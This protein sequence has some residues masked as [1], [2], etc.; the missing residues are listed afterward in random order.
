[1][2]YQDHDS[3]FMTQVNNSIGILLILPNISVVL[4]INKPEEKKDFKKRHYPYA[5]SSYYIS[6]L[7]SDATSIKIRINSLVL[8]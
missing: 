6:Y 8:V 1:M 4:G 3:F 2:L 7:A 5:F